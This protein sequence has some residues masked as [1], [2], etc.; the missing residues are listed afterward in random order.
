MIE[1]S[2]VRGYPHPVRNFPPS[3]SLAPNTLHLAGVGV[4]VDSEDP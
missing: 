1:W 4:K 2:R 3:P